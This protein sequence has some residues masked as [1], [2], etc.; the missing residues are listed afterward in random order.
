MTAC[1]DSWTGSIHFWN[2]FG[3]AAIG[4]P[5][6]PREHDI[7]LEDDVSWAQAL[8]HGWLR[9]RNADK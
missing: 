6:F 4:M 2:L 1:D 9:V 5:A 8:G 3:H 7:S